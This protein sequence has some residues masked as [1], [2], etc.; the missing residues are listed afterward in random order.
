VPAGWLGWRACRA[1]EW[2][3][4]HRTATGERREVRLPTARASS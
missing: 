3:A 2:L 4:D 1:R